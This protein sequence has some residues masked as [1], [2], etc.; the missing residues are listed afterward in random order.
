MNGFTGFIG[1]TK[2]A[3]LVLERMMD[4]I[5]H[6]GPTSSG[7]FTENEAALGFR[8]LRNIDE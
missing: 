3:S 6:R 8:S 5:R 1:E 7:I 2:N 4:K